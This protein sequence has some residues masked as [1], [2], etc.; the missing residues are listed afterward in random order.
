MTTGGLSIELKPR[1][2][3]SLNDL[4]TPEVSQ[5]SVPLVIRLSS[6]GQFMANE[7]L[8]NGSWRLFLEVISKPLAG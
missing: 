4:T 7:N 8:E 5:P 2:C 6:H 1:S 3:Q